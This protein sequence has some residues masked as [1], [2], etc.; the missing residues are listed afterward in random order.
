MIFETES[1]SSVHADENRVEE[2]AIE[3]ETEK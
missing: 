3:D 1:N 2:I